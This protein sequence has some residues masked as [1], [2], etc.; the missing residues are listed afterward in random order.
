M[1]WLNGADAP[2]APFH[3]LRDRL[4]PKIILECALKQKQLVFKKNVLTYIV[5]GHNH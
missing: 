2:L 3:W 5:L 1:T 4:R